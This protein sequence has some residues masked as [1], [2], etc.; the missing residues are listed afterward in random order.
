MVRRTKDFSIV[1]KEQK[2]FPT[3]FFTLKSFKQERKESMK[4]KYNEYPHTF[5]L[6]STTAIILPHLL[7]LSRSTVF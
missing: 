2:V 3:K 5:H 1:L 4:E 7:S 6:D